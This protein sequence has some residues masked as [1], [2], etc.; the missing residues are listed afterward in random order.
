MRAGLELACFALPAA[1]LIVHAR[2][3]A[4]RAAAA[5]WR[6]G[7][8]FAS[9]RAA[10]GPL[11]DLIVI[12]DFDGTLTSGTSAQCHDVIGTSERMPP[13]ARESFKPL[14]D[15]SSSIPEGH[16]YHGERWWVR[17]NQIMIE[18]RAPSREDLAAMAARFE[19][20]VG[21]I[22]LLHFLA[23][24]GVPVLIVSAGCADLIEAVLARHGALHPTQRLSSNRCV[25]DEATGDLVGMS[26]RAPVTSFNKADTRVRDAEWLAAHAR[27]R[28]LLVV[29][30]RLGDLRAGDGV[31]CSARLN[32]GVANVGGR[33]ERHVVNPDQYLD[34]GFD[35]VIVG[36]AA[37]FGPLTAMLRAS[38]DSAD[39]LK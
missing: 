9:R 12:T 14:L 6:V 8:A 32:V 25:W 2:R 30:D 27:R 33:S 39:G 23:D 11:D 10:L 38:R 1:A 35:A 18:A 15:F 36:A 17:A 24:H 13:A 3:L 20:R 21:A 29:G 5:S 37:G 7:S 31:P 26:P 16:A 22:E 34:E 19:P 28:S 4:A